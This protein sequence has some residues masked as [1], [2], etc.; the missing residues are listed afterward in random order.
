LESRGFLNELS[1]RGFYG[2]GNSKQRLI[3]SRHKWLNGLNSGLNA[4]KRDPKQKKRK[5]GKEGEGTGIGPEGEEGTGWEKGHSVASALGNLSK[6]GLNRGVRPYS[7][8]GKKKEQLS[9]G[10][11]DQLPFQGCCTQ[12]QKGELNKGP[13]GERTKLRKQ[14]KGTTREDRHGK[15][16]Y[17]KARRTGRKGPSR[18]HRKTEKPHLKSPAGPQPRTPNRGPTSRASKEKKDEK[19]SS[20]RASCAW[21][22]EWP[23]L[24][25]SAGKG[26]VRNFFDYCARNER[27]VSVKPELAY[28]EKRAGGAGTA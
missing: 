9:A 23:Q 19:N 11:N 14:A 20:K 6:H 13:K 16:D 22:E 28:T 17:R 18:R 21:S 27:M 24:G 26:C 7:R 8:R 2:K 10:G 3:K 25:K 15:V 1:Q 12:S 4:R 5:K